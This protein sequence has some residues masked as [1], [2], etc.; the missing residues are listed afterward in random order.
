MTETLTEG[1]HACLDMKSGLRVSCSGGE[2]WRAILVRAVLVRWE[3]WAG[4]ICGMVGRAGGV[5]CERFRG[6]RMRSLVQGRCGAGG[7]NREIGKK[8]QMSF[9]N[10]VGR[11]MVSQGW[12]IWCERTKKRSGKRMS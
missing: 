12:W 9:G 8:L 2:W 7:K 6:S 1:N 4:V 11:R 5:G 3:N 10:R